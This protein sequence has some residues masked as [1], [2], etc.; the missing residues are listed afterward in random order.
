MN[1]LLVLSALPT[2][3]FL[4]LPLHAEDRPQ[5]GEAFSRNMISPEKLLIDTFDPNAKSQVKW[6]VPLGSIT[7]GSPVIAQGKVLVGTN[8]D[9]PR[10]DTH[11]GDRGVLMCF[12]EADGALLWQLVVPK[13]DDPGHRRQIDHPRLGITS[14]PV[15]EDDRVYLVSNRSEVLCLDL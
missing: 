12:R 10:D 5:W 14:P 1:R 7:N 2:W 4:P 15:V 11:Q 6:C 9:V 13:L 3:L 8:N